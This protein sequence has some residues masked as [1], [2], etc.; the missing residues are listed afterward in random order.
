MRTFISWISG[1]NTLSDIASQH[2]ISPRT[3]QRRLTW[4]WWI[5]PTPYIDAHRIYDQIFLD[6]TYV[7]GGCLLIAA[8][9]TH[10]I[11]WH[12]A[13]RE[14]ADAYQTL[15]RDIAPP[16]M[17]V[18]DG[19]T[20]AFSA[21][22]RC[23]PHTPIQRCLVHATRV[24]R[25]Y[26]TSKPRTQAGQAIYELAKQ[27]PTITTI[28]Q[29]TQWSIRFHE[30]GQIYQEWMNEK[31]TITDPATGQRRRVFTHQRVRSAYQSLLH[32][33]R[34][35]FLFEYLQPP[36]GTKQPDH[37]AATTNTLEGGINAPLKELTRRHRGTSKPHQRTIIDWW[38]YLKTEAPDDPIDIA[39]SQNWGQAALSTAHELITHDTNVTTNDNG[40]PAEYD[41]A[42]DTEYQH[43]LGIQKGWVK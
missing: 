1:V 23:W 19:G 4:C 22:R 9:R 36:P 18:I 43:N 29:A 34:N 3:L 2:G 8:S 21:I 26:T 25:R 41:T 30:F 32:L 7:N 11:N 27:L 33:Y 40:A 20:G 42:I 17:A 6:A 10:V 13:H 35:A 38:L 37:M 15:I 39:R 31:T 14:T 5:T 28:D 24:V 16:H 12:W